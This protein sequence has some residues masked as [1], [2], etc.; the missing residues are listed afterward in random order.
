MLRQ[1]LRKLHAFLVEIEEGAHVGGND[2]AA[3]AFDSAAR[4]VR[5]DGAHGGR[6]VD[7]GSKF[8]LNFPTAKEQD[9]WDSQ[10]EE[11]E[12]EQS[13]EEDSEPMR[14]RDHN[15]VV[16]RPLSTRPYQTMRRNRLMEDHCAISVSV[17]V[18]C[19]SRATFQTAY[20]AP[21][22]SFTR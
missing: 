15:A 3:R 22:A 14:G 4:K 8:C 6:H 17:H 20:L 16:Q 18:I 10:S 13:S 21:L 9:G 1:E 19:I 2:T 7:G 5:G 11:E 12:E